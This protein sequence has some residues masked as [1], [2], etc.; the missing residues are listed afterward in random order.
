MDWTGWDWRASV[1][2]NRDDL[3]PIVVTMVAMA[4][5]TGGK[6]VETLPRHVYLGILELLRPAEA[7]LRRII[8][9]AAR[10]LVVPVRACSGP[11]G[12]IP[13]GKGKGARIPAFQLFDPRKNVDPRRR[14][15]PGYG[16]RIWVIGGDNPPAYT[17]RVPMPDDAVPAARL[18][19][20]LLA[21]QAALNDI[22][23]Q[24]RRLVRALARPSQ[25]WKQPMRPGRPPGFRQDGKDDIDEILTECETMAWIA[26]RNPKPG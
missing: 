17:K 6:I 20:R 15:T 1:K 7:I 16:P 3:L 14:T 23:G 10:G 21:L 4:G 25:R 12:S 19:R 26:M 24:A 22:P 8:V 5:L 13:R 18:C 9:M 11:S 2:R